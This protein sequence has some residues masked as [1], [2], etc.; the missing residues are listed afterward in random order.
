MSDTSTRFTIGILS[1]GA[2]GSA[3]GQVWTS[4]GHTCITTVIG[5]SPRTQALA[6][7]SGMSLV[8]T[9][10]EVIEA[11]DIIMSIVPPSEAQANAATILA[12]IHELKVTPLVV[13]LNAISPLTFHEIESAFQES[14]IEIIDGAISG[15][16][17]S[18]HEE[19]TL[20]L[21][22]TKAHHLTSLQTDRLTVEYLGPKSGLAS[23]T[24]MCTAAFLK[25]SNAIL[26]TTLNTAYGLGVVE[27]VITELE[28]IAGIS[29]AQAVARVSSTAS[30]ASRFVD[31]MLQIAATQASV[32]VDPG[33][34]EELA[35]VWSAIADTEL[36][37]HSP[38][39]SQLHTDLNEVLRQSRN[40]A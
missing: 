27:P 18:S 22:G 12:M 34:F 29:T 19:S 20:F 4:I 14:D 9:A 11:S 24:K 36:A 1:P 37:Q 30:K 40:N 13:D 7:Q 23:A 10:H 31:E 5:R 21:S 15:P 25:G 33:L 32:G 3:L 38:E 28:R 6:R 26:T 39:Q 17:P 8:P 2:M 35:Q 16:P